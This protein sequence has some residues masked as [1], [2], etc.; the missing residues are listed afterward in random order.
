MTL[1]A[2]VA[3]V[4][5]ALQISDSVDDALITMAATSASALIEGYCGRRFDTVSATK[6]FIADNNYLLKID[7]LISIS[8]HLGNAR[9]P[10]R[11]AE[12]RGRGAGIPFHAYPRDRRLPVALR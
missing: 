1:Y 4:K 10:T 2:S 11:T 7:D 8:T 9:L 5:A 6:L 3:Q 12:R